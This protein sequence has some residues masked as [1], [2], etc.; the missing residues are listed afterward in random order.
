MHAYEVNGTRILEFS[1]NDA[2]VSAPSESSALIGLAIEHQAALVILP[3]SELDGAF[4]LFQLKTGVAGD[5]IQKF[6][7]DRLRLAIIGD[8]AAYAEQSAALRAFIS[9]SNRGRTLWFSPTLAD[10]QA[11]LALE[12]NRG[13]ASHAAFSNVRLKLPKS[14]LPGCSES[15]LR[16]AGIVTLV[17]LK[18]NRSTC[19]YLP[20]SSVGFQLGR[21]P[22]EAG[23]SPEI[24]KPGVCPRCCNEFQTC[25][26][27]LGD[28]AAAGILR[29]FQK[30]SRHLDRN[31]PRR[32]H[33]EPSSPIAYIPIPSIGP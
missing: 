9:E 26:D 2:E 4:F 32:F 1:V 13:G 23:L 22:R 15:S 5:L 20:R 11:R 27:S 16:E 31:F 28:A 33:D 18:E 17:S 6:V 8:V 19:W 29:S 14:R 7:N 12:R 3:A 24:E 21:R 25:A 30:C 10:L